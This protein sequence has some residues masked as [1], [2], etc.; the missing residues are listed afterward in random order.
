LLKHQG[1]CVGILLG[2]QEVQEMVETLKK[3][4][5]ALVKK[6]FRARCR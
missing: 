3:T 4:H 5:P 1:E 2:R 6:S